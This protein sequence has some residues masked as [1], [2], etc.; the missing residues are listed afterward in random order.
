MMKSTKLLFVFWIEL[1][2]I[3]MVTVYFLCY[4]ELSFIFIIISQATSCII[5][6]IIYRCGMK[7]VE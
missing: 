6:G 1:F 5:F 3:Y 4:S 2:V 7:K